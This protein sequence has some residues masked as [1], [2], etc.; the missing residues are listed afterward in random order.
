MK[1]SSHVYTT[2][3]FM[4]FNYLPILLRKLPRDP[5][6]CLRY[7]CEQRVPAGVQ[8]GPGPGAAEDAE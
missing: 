4:N 3:S 8:D 2:P 1:V 6:G 7:K 5:E